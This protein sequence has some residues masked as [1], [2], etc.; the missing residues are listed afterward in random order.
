MPN[1]DNTLTDGQTVRVV[2]SQEDTQKV[3]TIP[4]SAIAVDQTG[5]YVFVVNDKN[6]VEQR[7]VKLGQQREGVVAVL[8]GVAENDL[9]VIQGHQ[10]IRAGASVSPQVQSL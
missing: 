9:V 2:L 5:P 4:K 8:D 10:R 1:V 6:V 3:V 7:R